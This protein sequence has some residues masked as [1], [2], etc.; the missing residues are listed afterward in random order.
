MRDT[1]L[2]P[3]F[4]DLFDEMEH[5][6]VL[7]APRDLLQEEVVPDRVEVTSQID[8]DHGTHPPQETP[9]DFRQRLMGRALGAIPLRVGTEVRLE[10]RFQNQLQRPLH[11]TIADARNLEFSDFAFTLW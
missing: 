8:L 9:S 7:D 11:H 5:G 10:D 3:G 4:Q 6:R 2:P 1:S